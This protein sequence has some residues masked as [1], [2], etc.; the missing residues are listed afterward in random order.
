M[1]KF[2]HFATL[3]DT[4]QEK[5]LF[6]SRIVSVMIG[7]ACLALLLIIRLIYLQLIEHT[8]YTTLARQNQMSLMPVEPQRGLIYDRN[9]VLLAENIP[10]YNLVVTPSRVPDLKTT[11]GELQKIISITDEEVNQFQRQRRLHRRFEAVPLKIKLNEEEVA[12]FSLDQYRFPGVSIQAEFIRHY[13]LGSV[14]APVVGYVGRINAEELEQVESSNYSATNFI[15]KTGI[16]KYYEEK[17]HG[18]VGDQQAETDARGQVVRVLS[19]TPS[20]P[21]NNLY[22]TIDSKLQIAA[23]KILGKQ[24][25]A[26]VAI[27]PHTGEVLAFVSNPSYDPN[28]FV[29]GINKKDYQALQSNPDEPLYN[30]AL[31]GRFAPGSTVKPLLSLKALSTGVITPD[32]TVNDPGWFQLPNSS[33]I[34]H[35]FHHLAR[36]TVNLVKAIAVSSDIYFYTLALK[37]G[38][39]QIQQGL[40]DFGFGQPTGIDLGSEANGVVPSPSW[41]KRTQHQAWFPGDTIITGIGQGYTLVTPLQLAHAVAAIATRGQRW[42]PHVLL[43]SQNAEGQLTKNQP[44]SLGTLTIQNKIWDVVYAGMR[45]VVTMPGATASQYF[46][47]AGYTAAGKTGTAQVFS[48]KQNQRYNAKMV[49]MRLRDNS[50]FIA[51]APVE[52]SKIA[53]AVIIQNGTTPAAQVARQLLDFYLIHKTVQ[54]KTEVTKAT[55]QSDTDE[56]NTD[57]DE[58]EEQEEDEDNS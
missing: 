51:F 13:P 33:H 26:I 56:K 8:V 15:G 54:Q 25:G 49:P 45:G 28:L 14:F 31:R 1:P 57:E 50:L 27:E 30:R 7:I 46:Q 34:Y 47:N 18:V 21:G 16:E 55:T 38:I 4:R 32:F 2:K 42:Q 39:E 35:G 36:G 22:L 48:L 40:T 43:Y 17:L 37:M 53:I 3:K 58:D 5:Q 11:L 9:G 44:A 6:Y 10:V 19:T 20:I 12:K 24:R 23:Q 52:N 41:K 29:K